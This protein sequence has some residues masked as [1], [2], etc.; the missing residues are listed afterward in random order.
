MVGGKS[1]FTKI[2]VCRYCKSSKVRPIKTKDG[3]GWLCEKCGGVDVSR[4][5]RTVSYEMKR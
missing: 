2:R 4:K 1:S 5:R 3:I